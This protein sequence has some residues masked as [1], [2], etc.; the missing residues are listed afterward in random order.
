MGEN[1]DEALAEE[2]CCVLC[3]SKVLLFGQSRMPPD[4]RLSPTLMEIYM[5]T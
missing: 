2:D 3:M 5:S 1:G 4:S